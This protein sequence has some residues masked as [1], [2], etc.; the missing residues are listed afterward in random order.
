MTTFGSRIRL[1]FNRGF[2]DSVET[3][4]LSAALLPACVISLFRHGCPTYICWAGTEVAKWMRQPQN[5]PRATEA[6]SLSQF[7]RKIFSAP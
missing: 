3:D 5:W 1:D 2:F 7:A 6:I 4:I